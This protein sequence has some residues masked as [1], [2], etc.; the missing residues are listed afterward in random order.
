MLQ[1]EAERLLGANSF[2]AVSIWD[3]LCMGRWCKA[4][5]LRTTLKSIEIAL[6]FQAVVAQVAISV[7]ERRAGARNIVS[8]FPA[9]V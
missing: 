2:E 7:T 9:E 1:P 8:I 5:H 3:K 6:G 4:A